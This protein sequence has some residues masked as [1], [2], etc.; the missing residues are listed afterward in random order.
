MGPME[1]QGSSLVGQT[2]LPLGHLDGRGG[3]ERLNLGANLPRDLSK[4]ADIIL[5]VGSIFGRK[6]NSAS[7]GDSNS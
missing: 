4:E 3:L 5:G 6:R 2:P 1:V 7:S